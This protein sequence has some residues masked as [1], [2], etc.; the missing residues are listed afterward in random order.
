MTIFVGTFRTLFYGVAFV[1][2]MPAR[3]DTA[4]SQDTVNFNCIKIQESALPIQIGEVLQWAMVASAQ[5]CIEGQVGPMGFP[6]RTA[7]QTA[8]A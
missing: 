6:W 5:Y 3:I 4:F 8:A 7:S 2:T 1:L